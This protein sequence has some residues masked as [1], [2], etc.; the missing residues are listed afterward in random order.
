[1]K[2]SGE[3]YEEY[4]HK[5]TTTKTTHRI[6]KPKPPAKVSINGD[7]R[8]VTNIQGKVAKGGKVSS[9]EISDFIF[10]SQWK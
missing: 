7:I 8:L 6:Q 2:K 10:A 4:F 9:D 3:P 5:T 1:M